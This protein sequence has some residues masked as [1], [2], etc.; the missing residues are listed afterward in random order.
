MPV[1]DHIRKR[2][3]DLEL[4][5]REVAD[6]IGCSTAAPLMWE[7]GRS[8]PEL[9][10]WPAIIRFLGCDPVA[11]PDTSAELLLTA[12]RRLGYSHRRLGQALG[13]DPSTIYK[14][15]NGKIP[16]NVRSWLRLKAMFKALGIGLEIRRQLWPK[17]FRAGRDEG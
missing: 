6:E 13:V 4:L 8:N 10:F 7:K 2:R 9:R 5:Q 17:R 14:W 12:R 11:E 1:G 15:E 16:R 3:M